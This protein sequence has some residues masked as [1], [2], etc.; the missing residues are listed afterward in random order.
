MSALPETPLV[1]E[2]LGEPVGQVLR[3][4][5]P[6]PA[7]PVTEPSLAQAV[8]EP[9]PVRRPVS[10]RQRAVYRRRRIVAAVLVLVL[11]VLL[12]LAVQAVTA[13]ISQLATPAEATPAPVALAADDPVRLAV[14]VGGSAVHL[15]PAGVDGRGVI[16]PPAGEA[17]WYTGHDR[18]TPGELGTA[19]IVGSTADA[20]GDPTP[21][22]GVTSLT[23]GDRVVVV[24]GDGVTLEL[25]VVSAALVERD[26]VE[27]SDLLW[28][29]QSETRRVALV[30]S[31][32]VSEGDDRGTFLAVAELG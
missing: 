30:T 23:E 10:A 7:Q 11:T 26:D 28:G 24:F 16:D 9:T 3:T 8:T 22:A 25:D 1:E 20:D 14:P 13:F 17:V 2:S 18:V 5:E 21:F 27:S 31:D 6:S 12:V 4:E 15:S 19:V 32:E 29:D